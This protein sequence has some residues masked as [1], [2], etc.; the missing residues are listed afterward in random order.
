MGTELARAGE[1]G[2]R[3]DHRAGLIEDTHS[4][5]NAPGCV[6]TIK[7]GGSFAMTGSSTVFGMASYQ[8][9]SPGEASTVWT[10]AAPVNFTSGAIALAVE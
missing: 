4:R 7:Y 10:L 2:P 8:V 3:R 9:A 1:T 5:P 6:V